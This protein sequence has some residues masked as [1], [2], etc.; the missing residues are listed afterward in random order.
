MNRDEIEGKA[1]EVK[2]KMK[3]AVADLTDNDRLHSE[4]KADELAG[5]VQG[6]V[7]TAKRKVGET[8]EKIGKTIKK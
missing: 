8:V 6:T 7:G 1:R 5:E 2:G 4:G 3:Q